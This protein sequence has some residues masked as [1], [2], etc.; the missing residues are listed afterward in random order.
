MRFTLRHKGSIVGTHP[1]ET[2]AEALD[3]YARSCG[4]TDFADLCKKSNTTR[5]D[6]KVERVND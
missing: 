2:D 3:D 1:G 5:D 6:F 4:F